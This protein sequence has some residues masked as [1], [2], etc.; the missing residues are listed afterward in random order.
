M[1]RRQALRNIGLGAGAIIVGPGT[2]SLLHSC[3]SEPEYDW[4]PVFLSAAQ[5]YTLK[6]V[7]EIIIPKTD[8][9]G[10]SDLNIAQF[11]DS[12]MDEV[13]DEQRRKRFTE[14]AN[15]FSSAFETEYEK[16]QEEG[17]KQEFEEIT[18]KYLK[19]SPA[20]QE[21]YVTRLTETQDAQKQQ[22]EMGIDADAGAYAYLTTVR[23]LGIWAWKNSEEIG[24]NVMWYDP[25]PG[26]Y[27]ACGPNDEL[28]NGKAMSL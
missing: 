5:G 8:T 19:A 1:N 9:P 12:Y 7:L 13:A 3:K 28:G 17:V 4:Q 26:I 15:A 20:E 10:A 16:A 14:A 23:E 22:T 2:L 25:I 21:Q 6:N 18:R 24:E 27:I 11:I